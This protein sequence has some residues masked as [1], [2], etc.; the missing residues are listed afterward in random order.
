MI[1]R[2]DLFMPPTVSQYGVL[3]HFTKKFHEALQRSGVNSRILEAQH[4]NPKPFLTELFKD[5]PD[6][7]L[8]FNGL[9]PDREGHFFCDM[10]QIPHVALVVDSPNGFVQLAKSPSTIIASVD[11]DACDFFRGIQAKNVFF[12]PHGVEKNL[13]FNSKNEERTYDVTFLSS[14]I[15]YEKIQKEW[16]KTFPP[17][18]YKVMQDSIELAL[19]DPHLSYV[20][21]FVNTLNRNFSENMIEALGFSIVELLDQLEMYLRGR[22]RVD[23]I[24]SIRDA[25]IDIFG[26]AADSTTWKKQLGKKQDNVIIHEGVAYDQALEIMHQSK[27]VL[28]NC[29]WIKNGIH[30]RTLAAMACGALVLAEDTPYVRENFQ[31]GKNICLYRNNDLTSLNQKIND[32]LQNEAVRL[33]IAEAGKNEVAQHHTWDQR[34]ITLLKEL[35]PILKKMQTTL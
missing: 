20:N 21:A 3:N 33:E 26:A 2:I 19:T 7:T 31:D 17:Q 9:L 25:R 8:S 23:L 13:H 22:T 5:V 32:Y 27:I 4:D 1:K 16:K 18:L 10:V 15:D 14:C 6:C 29:A 11:R 28:N 34:A 12:L 24:R 30:E 35:D